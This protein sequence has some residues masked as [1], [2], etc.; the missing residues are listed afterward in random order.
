VTAKVGVLAA[1]LAL[2]ALAACGQK[3]SE[4]IG[5]TE[6]AALLGLS[7][8]ALPAPPAD[9]TSRVSGDPKAAA[10][11]QALFFDASFSGPLLDGDNDGSATTLGVKGQPGKVSC[12]GCHVPAAGFLDD[13]SL[14]KQASLAAGWSLRR[15][16][17]LLDVGQS[18]LLHWDGR[19]DS[20]W[21]QVFG[22]LEA[23]NE[24]NSSRLFVA[25]RLFATRKADLEALFGPLPS[26][27][28]PA[29][30]PPL[31]PTTTGC[32]IAPGG[33]KKCRGQPGDGA[34]FD[35]MAPADQD[36]V[37]TW[38]VAAG[39]AIGAYLRTLSCGPGAFDRFMHGD[40]SALS[41]S[42]QRG[43]ALFVGKGSCVSCH[44]GP[45][46]SDEK[47]H[48]V[49]LRPALV[50]VV[51]FDDGDPGASKGLAALLADPLNSRGAFSDGTD[52]RLP[53]APSAAMLGAFRTPKLRCA[54]RR[55]SFLH[56][57]QL[58][59]LA[60]VVAFFNAGG[61]PAGYPGTSEL[62]PLG[63]SA[64]EQA[65]LVAFLES[66]DGPGPAATL[67]EAP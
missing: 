46:L 16:P 11:G 7:P 10:L 64:A 22:P 37:T 61:H 43:A 19:R 48:N 35:A 21:S 47:F 2:A 6:R 57:G 40:A 9:P 34:E 30:F 24:M 51:V 33:A 66:L 32:V 28:D 1:A 17:S 29:R 18:R 62:S 49:G 65:D 55:P 45:F 36:A 50:S 56:T 39:K 5:P 53:A 25:E 44:S 20:T 42:Q 8:D 23:A 15:T 38:V 41:P 54:S 31:S 27:A 26:L 12:A 4:P 59:T 14:G 67:L 63:L 60:Q 52:G 13:R 3:A 58:A